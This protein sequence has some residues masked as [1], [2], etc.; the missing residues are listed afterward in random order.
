MSKFKAK[1]YLSQIAEEWDEIGPIRHSLIISGKDISFSKIL[2]PYI[3]RCIPKEALSI[4]D[5]GCGTGDLTK[6]ISDGPRTLTGVDISPKSIEIAKGSNSSKN[7]LYV[8]DSIEKFCN[9]TEDCF[10]VCVANMLFMDTPD[11]VECIKSIK[12]CLSENGV[13]I[14]TILHPFFFEFNRGNFNNIFDYSV[15]NIVVDEFKVTSAERSGKFR[16]HW[17]RPIE[18][19]VTKLA[20]AGFRIK[21]LSELTP[22]KSIAE[23]YG[24]FGSTPR[25]LGC[26]AVKG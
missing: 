16:S 18:F 26:V 3:K 20:S 19:Y 21:S 17:H 7:I 9:S 2:V 4:L 11:Y 25:F 23:Q 15:R 12:G 24:R 8:N 14:F 6:E 10:D 5:A 22:P 13:L 1:N